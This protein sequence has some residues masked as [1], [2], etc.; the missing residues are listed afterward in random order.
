V[1]NFFY[2]HHPLYTRR[3]WYLANRIKAH[4]REQAGLPPVQRANWRSRH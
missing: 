1:K 2:S 4:Y 3:R